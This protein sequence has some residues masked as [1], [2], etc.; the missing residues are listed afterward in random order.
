MEISLLRKKN[1]EP[2]KFIKIYGESSR[3]SIWVSNN[4]RDSVSTIKDE[5]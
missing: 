5:I 1:I 2:L 3:V 4:N